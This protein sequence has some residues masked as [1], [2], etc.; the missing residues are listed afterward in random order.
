MFNCFVWKIQ[1][2]LDN[3]FVSINASPYKCSSSI[4]VSGSVSEISRFF[5]LEN[6]RLKMDD[7]EIS[8]DLEI[9]KKPLTPLVK[10]IF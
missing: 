8:R 4:L 10:S 7:L 1:E 5:D 2:Q 3:I 9:W 6:A